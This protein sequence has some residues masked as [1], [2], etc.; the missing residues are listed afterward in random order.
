MTTTTLLFIEPTKGQ[1]LTTV[2]GARCQHDMDCS[3][4]IK[5]SHCSMDG[6]CDCSPFHVKYNQ[7]I[8]LQG[9]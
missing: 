1:Q 9:N 5:G 3:D 7:T 2:L 6:I 4:T 8:C